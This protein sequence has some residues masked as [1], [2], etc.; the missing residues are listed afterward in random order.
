MHRRMAT[1]GTTM[2]LCFELLS[3][4]LIKVFLLKC[5][6]KLLPTH[7]GCFTFPD[8][9]KIRRRRI[10]KTRS[11]PKNIC[12]VRAK[13]I[14]HCAKTGCLISKSCVVSALARTVKISICICPRQELLKVIVIISR[15]CREFRQINF[16][17]ETID[18]NDYSFYK[19]TA[20]ATE[21]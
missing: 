3:K 21:V 14:P 2:G 7:R 18:G 8:S 5:Q 11:S 9:A 15:N 20:L 19:M 4:H 10:S 16:P 13:P 12:S 17:V 6:K 1:S